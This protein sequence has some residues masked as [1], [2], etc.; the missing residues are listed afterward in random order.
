[1]SSLLSASSQ[2]TTASPF[3][4][5]ATLESTT[6]SAAEVMVS[7]KV[8]EPFGPPAKYDAWTRS[9]PPTD[10]IQVATAVPFSLIAMRAWSG[11]RPE[12]LTFVEARYVGVADAEGMVMRAPAVSDAATRVPVKVLRNMV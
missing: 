9:T 3:A 10:R 4:L 5:I 11:R 2:V 6:T 8:Q 12:W 7:G 1:M